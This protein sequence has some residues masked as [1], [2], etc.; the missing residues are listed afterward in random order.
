MSTATAPTNPPPPALPLCADA[1]PDALKAIP[2]WLVWRYTWRADRKRK[3]AAGAWTKP[4]SSART[5]GHASST[6]PTTWCDFATALAAY[7]QGGWDGIGFV[8]TP[9]LGLTF[10]DLDHCRHG[11]TGEIEPWARQLIDELGTYTEVSPSGTGIRLIALGRKPSAARSKKG[12][13]ELYD[14]RT[15]KGKQGGRYLTITGHRLPG[16]PAAIASRPEAIADVYTRLFAGDAP[17]NAHDGHSPATPPPSAQGPPTDEEVLDRALGNAR[18][19][20]RF[21]RLW[22]GGTLGNSASE[23]DLALL[24]Y[25]AF[26]TGGDRAQMDRLFRRSGLYRKKWEREDYREPTIT[27]ALAGRTD[28]FGTTTMNAKPAP[29]KKHCELLRYE[30]F[31]GDAL[32]QP[33]RRFVTEG[34]A[35]IGCDP[36]FVALPL[37]AAL[38][39]AIGNARRLELKRGWYEP[40]VIWTVT[41]GDSGTLKSP[42]HELAVGPVKARQD[43][44]FKEHQAAL[45]HYQAEHDN[46]EQALVQWQS[47]KTDP[48]PLPPQEKEPVCERVLVSDP[49]VEAVAGLLEHAPRGVLL[50]RDELSGWLN[51][52]DAH[53]KSRGGDVAHWLEMHRAGPILYDR[54][55]GP[56]KVVHVPR[57]ATSIAGGV[58]TQTLRKALGRDHFDNGL[59]ARLLLAMP[60]RRKRAW[61]DQDI[62]PDLVKAVEQVFDRLYALDMD[63]STGQ[64]QPRTLTFTPEA[65]GA[66]VTFFN[67]HADEQLTLTGDLASAWSKL[68]GYAARFALVLQCALWAASGQPPDGPLHVGLGCVEAGITL[69]NW[70]GREARRCYAA[71]DESDQDQDRRRLVEWIGCRN[72]EVTARQLQMGNR[73]YRDS[74][75]AAEQALQELVQAGLGK[76]AD[77]PPTDKGG[78]P[79][80]VFRL[81]NANE[82]ST[83]HEGGEGC[84]DVDGP[85][86]L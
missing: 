9:A 14:G 46:F 81:V 11:T 27:R 39:A 28:F 57:A 82:T 84:V 43:V 79:T 86:Q 67:T 4:P 59:A 12:G 68:E 83:Q 64:P 69:A 54:K 31:P 26:W 71:L 29:P 47:N 13:I 53:K 37:L 16:T 18:T 76:W 34:A 10:I 41:V 65:K 23:D 44:A 36:S 7:Q 61:T 6:D 51:S 1:V 52:F 33:L 38:A 78:R 56:I 32:P 80:R 55:T 72:G 22:E 5:G 74:V 19:G 85:P 25:L 63:T 62:D 40:A 66:Y 17:P 70:F 58:Q 35:A 45:D 21:R 42:A 73:R 49:T 24:N 20:A 50:A 3:G 48:K 75:E 60:P 77:A 2:H 30:P 8:P 15:G